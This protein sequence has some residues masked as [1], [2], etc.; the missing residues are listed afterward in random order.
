ML[1]QKSEFVDAVR[2]SDICK[3]IAKRYIIA[4]IDYKLIS[5]EITEDG[6]LVKSNLCGIVGGEYPYF[7]SKSG[8]VLLDAPGRKMRETNGVKK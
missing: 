2:R 5:C 3:G 1:S 4:G 6:A 8:E 7:V